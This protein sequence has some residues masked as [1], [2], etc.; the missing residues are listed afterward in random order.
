M[1]DHFLSSR[2]NTIASSSSSSP[3]ISILMTVSCYKPRSKSNFGN[4][5][6]FIIR[7]I[8]ELY[9]VMIERRIFSYVFLSFK[10]CEWLGVMF[11]KLKK[12]DLSRDKDS[13]M[14]PIGGLNGSFWKGS[15]IY[16]RSLYKTFDQ[17]ESPGSFS[18]PLLP[19]VSYNHSI[20]SS[21]RF[22][23]KMHFYRTD[24]L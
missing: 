7:H 10:K 5:F 20:F 12:G 11:N 1:V 14:F 4:M 9:S 3:R 24:I 21:L 16:T 18:P 19:L 13:P 17:S 23:R 2:Y 8:H 15:S 22:K 6:V